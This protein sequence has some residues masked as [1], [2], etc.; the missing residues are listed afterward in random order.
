[1]ASRGS[2]QIKDEHLTAQQRDHLNNRLFPLIR[3]LKRKA[4]ARLEDQRRGE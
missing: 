3:D 2:F 1:M 4:R